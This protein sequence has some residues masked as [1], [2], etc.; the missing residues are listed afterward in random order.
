MTFHKKLGKNYIVLFSCSRAF[1]YLDVNGPNWSGYLSEGKA[2]DPK[3]FSNNES[4]KVLVIPSL[5]S[6]IEFSMLDYV[7][8]NDSSIHDG[9]MCIEMC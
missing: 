8:H 4:P 6:E 9:F 1:E 3:G 7:I 2:M 5:K